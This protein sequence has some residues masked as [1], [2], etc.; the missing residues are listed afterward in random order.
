MSAGICMCT[1]SSPAMG[2]EPHKGGRGILDHKWNQWIRR[3]VVHTKQV[4]SRL[5]Q[6]R[7]KNVIPVVSSFH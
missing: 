6:S 4:A 1:R 5:A 3:H 7:P 2:R